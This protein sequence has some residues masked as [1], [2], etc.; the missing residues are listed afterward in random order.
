MSS[1][2]RVVL[3]PPCLLLLLCSAC[4][5]PF[6]LDNL[7]VDMTMAEATEAFG[8]PSSTSM[9]ELAQAVELLQKENARVY[10]RLESAVDL[11]EP[12]GPVAQRLEE[13]SAQALR[14]LEEFI[15]ELD[16]A[17]S[18]HGAVSTWVYPHEEA[19][20]FSYPLAILLFGMP[21]WGDDH[22]EKQQ[23]DLLFEGNK[24]ASWKKRVVR[25]AFKGWGEGQGVYHDPF[26]STTFHQY[27]SKKDR[28]H[29]KKG[30]KHHHD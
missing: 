16:D 24:L 21:F 25:T 29:H 28:K 2:P 7:K 27:Q 18:E 3:L 4:V 15:A 23:V 30:H 13:S 6:P 5:T 22:L 9:E 1:A 20:W 12:L 10:E 17:S 14:R 19:K 26:P 11:S 8:E